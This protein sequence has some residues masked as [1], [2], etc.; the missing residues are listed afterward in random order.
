[1]LQQ[2]DGFTRE[3][4]ND[5]RRIRAAWE[6]EELYKGVGGVSRMWNWGFRTSSFAEGRMFQ[7]W[8]RRWAIFNRRGEY[9]GKMARV[10]ETS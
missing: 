4:Q 8:E 9:H 5:G 2:I 10:Q 6:R 1:M 3:E 7:V